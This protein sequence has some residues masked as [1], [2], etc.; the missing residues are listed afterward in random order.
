MVL[1]QIE[2]AKPASKDRGRGSRRSPA[3]LSWDGAHRAPLMSA[4]RATVTR[5]TTQ[6]QGT[7]S[8]PHDLD[9]LL[10]HRLLRQ[11]GGF[12][13]VA[14]IREPFRACRTNFPSR[15]VHDIPVLETPLP[16]R[17]PCLAR[18]AI[19]APTTT[20]FSCIVDELVELIGA[21]LPGF[22]EADGKVPDSL[23]PADGRVLRPV[24]R[25]PP[26]RALGEPAPA[27]QPCRAC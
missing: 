7:T 21:V 23:A 27:R 19:R 26:I 4:S 25:S 22:V 20:P 18:V 17:F 3:S 5:S 8:A 15:N 9:V 24:R 6:G 12:E 13:G 10:R 2:A 16:R 1:P 11:P 14:A